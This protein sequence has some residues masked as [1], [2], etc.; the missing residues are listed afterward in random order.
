[1]KL[2][3]RNKRLWALYLEILAIEDV[4]ASGTQ[5]HGATWSTATPGEIEQARRRLDKARAE[6]RRRLSRIPPSEIA[7]WD[8]YP[9]LVRWGLTG[10]E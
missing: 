9:D 2:E 10:G 1:M 5:W 8:V 6:F 4:I 7:S 3:K